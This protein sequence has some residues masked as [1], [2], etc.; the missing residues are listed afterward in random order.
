MQHV[1][2]PNILLP[3]KRL[4]GHQSSINLEVCRYVKLP[5]HSYKLYIGFHRLKNLNRH[6]D[7]KG[8]SIRVHKNTKKRP[9]NRTESKDVEKIKG[10]IE[11]FAD[12]HAMPLPGR[13]QPHKDC[14]VMLLPSN[15]SKSFVYRF[16]I[17]ACR[18]RTKQLVY[19]EGHLK[20]FGESCVLI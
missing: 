17:R 19:H 9:H 16:Y 1:L 20:I 5:S 11:Q 13:L 3:L 15:M 18:S 4:C 2:Y 8:L 12:N 6:Y 7:E 10:F 14:R